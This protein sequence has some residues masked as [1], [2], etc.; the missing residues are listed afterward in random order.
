MTLQERNIPCQLPIPRGGGGVGYCVRS[1]E[2]GL[3]NIITIEISPSL[4]C[5]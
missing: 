3:C 5:M 4:M 2:G 1:F